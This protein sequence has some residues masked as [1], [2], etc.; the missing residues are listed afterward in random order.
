MCSLSPAGPTNK[1]ESQ[2]K[3]AILYVRVLLVTSLNE[4]LDLFVPLLITI[5]FKP[6]EFERA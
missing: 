6:K 2:Y 1:S 4:F 3:L 5:S